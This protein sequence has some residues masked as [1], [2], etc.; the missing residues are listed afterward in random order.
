MDKNKLEPLFDD[1]EVVYVNERYKPKNP[2]DP[3]IVYVPEPFA[4]NK[5]RLKQLRREK[6]FPV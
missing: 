3:N 4:A 2:K 6:I 1:G 5:A